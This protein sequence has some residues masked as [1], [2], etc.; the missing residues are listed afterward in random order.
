MNETPRRAVFLDRDGTI[1]EDVDYLTSPEQIRIL[2][3]AAEALRTL[4]EAGFLLVV[5]TNQSA[6]ARGWLTEE[7]L[8]LIH[9]ELNRRLTSEGAGLDAL[10][11]CPH[12]PEGSVERYARSCDCRKPAAGLLQRAATEWDIAMSDSYMIGDSERDMEAGRKAGCHTIRIGPDCGGYADV[13]AKSLTHA[14]ELILA[15]EA[16]RSS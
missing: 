9:Q 4:K 1:I 12:L 7:E 15:R 6:I 14:V 16:S 11:Y 13:A 3:G 5:V 8:A 10:Y 2:P